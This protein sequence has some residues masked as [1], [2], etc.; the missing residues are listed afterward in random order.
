MRALASL[1]L[2]AQLPAPAEYRTLVDEYRRNGTPQVIELLAMSPE[3]VRTAL[4]S[5]IAGDS[6]WAWEE[7]RAAAVL[8][9]DAILHLLRAG[10]TSGVDMHLDAAQ[11]L[12][13]RT[14][15]LQPRQEDFAWRWYLL[16]PELLKA[17]DAR[18][19]SPP[20]SHYAAIRWPPKYARGLLLHG[21]S[22]EFMGNVEGRVP[23]PGDSA[24]FLSAH[25]QSSWF[26]AAT[27]AY[28]SALRMNPTL[29][30]ARLHLGRIRMVQGQRT[31]AASL[32]E[33][34]LTAEDPTVVYLAALFLGSIE[35]REDRFTAAEAFYTQA[36][37]VWPHGQAGSLALSQLLSRTGRDREARTVL[38]GRL[39][40]GTR[41]IEPMWSYAAK[42]SD[43]LATR[44]DMLRAE[45]WR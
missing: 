11:R 4:T 18:K 43:E 36:N 32:L 40:S 19:F 16:V 22:L 28:S 17:L 44:F 6:A 37:A 1:I 45:V 20:L 14:M 34:A 10:S 2:L 30:A 3:A 5:A 39:T 31:E 38:A 23:R 26:A 12:L 35:E 21:I 29:H 8:H 9:T 42:P 15:T 7:T 25:S 41:P 13:T 33:E 27:D 24:L